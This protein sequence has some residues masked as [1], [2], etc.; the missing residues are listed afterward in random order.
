MTAQAIEEQIAA[1]REV[2]KKASAS[3][4]FAL[5]FLKDARIISEE[6]YNAKVSEL[7]ATGIPKDNGKKY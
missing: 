3:P 7:S 5:K 2:G 6:V 4:E 1:I